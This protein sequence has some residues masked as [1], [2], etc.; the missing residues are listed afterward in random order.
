MAISAVVDGYQQT[1]SNL[2]CADGQIQALASGSPASIASWVRATG[3]ER[4]FSAHRRPVDTFAMAASRLSDAEVDLDPVEET[5]IALQRAGVITSY[6]RGLLQV[7]YL[8]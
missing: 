3:A 2:V 7:G 8:R 5:L 6:Q 4:G 1:S